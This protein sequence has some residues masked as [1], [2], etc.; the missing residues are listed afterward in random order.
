[1]F[2]R[3]LVKE[4]LTKRDGKSR[5]SKLDYKNYG[6]RTYLMNGNRV[7]RPRVEGSY[8]RFDFCD[9]PNDRRESISTVLAT[10]TLAE[11]VTAMNADYPAKFVTIPFFK[12]NDVNK[13]TTSSIIPSHSIAFID[14]YRIDPA[15]CWVVYYIN[16]FKRVESLCSYSMDTL[17]GLLSTGSVPTSV[18]WD[19][20]IFS[21]DDDTITFDAD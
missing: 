20:I 11:L 18:T 9:N 14:T 3:T 21:F 12:F 8:T 19:S 7:I 2:F 4:W 10:I 1:M 15:Y 5:V 16:D 6:G 13:P 17:A